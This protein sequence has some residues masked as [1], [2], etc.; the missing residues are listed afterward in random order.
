MGPIGASGEPGLPG[1]N[2]CIIMINECLCTCIFVLFLLSTLM[3]VSACL[4]VQGTIGVD[5][6]RGEPG[7]DGIPGAQGRPGK[8]VS[9]IFYLA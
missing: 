9:M 6:L 3:F 4:S 2:V 7:E 5:G 1:T 8:R